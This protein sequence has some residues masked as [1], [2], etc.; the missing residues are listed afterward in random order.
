MFTLRSWFLSGWLI[1]G[2]AALASGESRREIVADFEFDKDPEIHVPA[3]VTVYS[4][5]LGPLWLKA[6]ARPEA[7][8]QRMAADAIGRAHAA[9]FPNLKDAVPNLVAVL[10]APACHPTVRLAAARALVLLDA[11]ESAPQLAECAQKYVAD[12]RQLV[13]P[14]LARWNYEPYREIWRARLTKDGAWRR[15]VIL[16]IRCLEMCQ[17]TSQVPVLLKIVH[18]PLRRPD[19]RLEAAQAAGLLVDSGLESGARG[20]MGGESEMRSVNHLCAARLIAHHGRDVHELLAELAID[21][22]PAVAFLALTRL[23][24]ID[25]HLVLPLA[26][27]SMQNAD[28]KVRQCGADAYVLLPDPQRVAVLA[29][30][31]DD[32]HPAVRG[33]VRDSLY[34]LAERP[35]LDGP[36]RKAAT[37]MLAGERWRGLEQAALLLAALDHKPAAA[38]LVELLE[39]DRPEVGIA[40]AWGLKKLA[41][42]ETLPAMFDK[43]RRNTE[44]R[45]GNL[46]T[47]GLDEQTAHLF[48]SMGQLRHAPADPLLREYIP[49]DYRMGERSRSSAIWSLGWLHLGVPDDQMAVQLL[50]RYADG[51]IPPEMKAVKVA[52]MV[53]IGRMKAVSQVPALRKLLG[54]NKV[55]PTPIGLAFRWAVNELTG[56]LL[57]EPDPPTAGKSDWFLEPLAD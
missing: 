29:R 11:K 23:I 15:D 25:P 52:A 36:I 4:D 30:L 42:P 47:D 17:D 10:T 44:V 34:R 20:M 57:P 13:E 14:A 55:A 19:V 38:R 5:R 45:K 32:P 39:N 16:A 31:L 43:A 7:D 1:L 27:W 48:E 46:T 35:E 2:F 12:L 40:A 18:D 33:S 41:I 8:M 50:E 26:E 6:L 37:D 21:A 22:E 3:P 49:K 53:T 54:D 9:G 56:E 24:E 28:P 51:G